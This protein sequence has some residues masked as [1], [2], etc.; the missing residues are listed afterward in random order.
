VSD[1][2]RKISGRP[3]VTGCSTAFTRINSRLSPAL[4]CSN[5]V[6]GNFGNKYEKGDRFIFEHRLSPATV[7]GFFYLRVSEAGRRPS[8][9]G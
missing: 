7:R 9:S 3:A 4:G 8:M 5:A 2:A 6:P 1:A